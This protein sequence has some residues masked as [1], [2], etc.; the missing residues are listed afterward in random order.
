MAG[1][2]ERDVDEGDAVVFEVIDQGVERLAHVPAH[3]VA[4]KVAGHAEREAVQ[5]AVEVCREITAG[6]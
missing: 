4:Q 5:P 2:R 6:G 3:F 1:V